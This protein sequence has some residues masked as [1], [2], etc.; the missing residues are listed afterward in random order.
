MSRW[1]ALSE[2][3]TF[4]DNDWSFITLNIIT[5]PR[6]ATERPEWDSGMRDLRNERS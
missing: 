3:R 6:S 4:T 2:Q 1:S 5:R